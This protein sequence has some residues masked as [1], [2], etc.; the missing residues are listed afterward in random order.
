M[1]EKEKENFFCNKQIKD[2]IKL[3]WK[4]RNKKD[5]IIV[6]S[7]NLKPKYNIIFNLLKSK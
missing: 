2:W 7:L 1:S 6:S 5:G 4:N 3:N